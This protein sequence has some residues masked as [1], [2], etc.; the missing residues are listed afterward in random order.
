MFALN[1]IEIKGFRC[2][3]NATF[4]FENDN[5]VIF[6]GKNAIGKTSVVEAIYYLA[7]G[8]SFKTTK[9]DEIIQKNA[10]N[11]AMYIKATFNNGETTEIGYDGKNKLIKRNTKKIKT[12]S[13]M[14]GYFMI[15]L[16]TPDDLL[17]VKGD[18]KNRRKFIDLSL[19]QVDKE[20]LNALQNAKNALKERNEYLKTIDLSKKA[21]DYS[22]LDAITK[23]YIDASETV[24][25][26]RTQFIAEISDTVVD[27]V[28]L[29][30]TQQDKVSL[31]YLPNVN[32]DN[33]WKTYAE[34]KEYDISAKTTTWGINRDDFLVYIND[35]KA[36]DTASQ[37]QIRT[38]C[39]ALKLAVI[40]YYK[41]KT[42][43]IL[44]ILDD[45]FSELDENR[46]NKILEYVGENNQV[47]I[48]ST[49]INLLS[50]KV[51]KNS[52]II[53]ITRGE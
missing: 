8:R 47:F 38:V 45:I 11:N 42:N 24:E 4:N 51:L 5:K 25:K 12:L 22:F 32:V 30:S 13:E 34:R 3:E 18:P 43:N 21:V 28:S 50:E 20:Y 7:F 29:I 10:K 39:L 40:K 31:N 48:T 14:L 49:N 23:A 26:K 52:K 1:K 35:S 15:G 44:I 33:F 36:E 46:Q 6:V 19:C 27:F 37:G 41:K 9:D 53:E 16:F 2:Y 17:L